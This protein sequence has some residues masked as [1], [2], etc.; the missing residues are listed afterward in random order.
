MKKYPGSG[1]ERRG[2]TLFKVAPALWFTCVWLPLLIACG[3]ESAPSLAEPEDSLTHVVVPSRG[4]PATLDVATWNLE[5]FGDADRGPANDAVQ[6]QRAREIVAGSD[7]DLW[8]LQEISDAADFGE[9]LQSLPGYSG[10]LA[11]DSF[12]DGGADWYSDFSDTEQKVGIVYRSD[13]VE[14][15]SARI[16]LTELDYE[17]AGRPPLEVRIRVTIAGTTEDLVV[18]VLH[19]KANTQPE[20][21]QRRR[22]AAVGLRR[23][24]DDV[25]P[26]HPVLVVG[27]WNDDLDQSI[28]NGRDTPYRTFIDASAWTFLTL[29]VSEAGGS[30][31]LGFT[32]MVDHILASDE[33]LV[34]YEEGSASI[35]QVDLTVPD[36][37]ETTSDHLPVLARFRL[38]R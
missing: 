21:W 25:W 33:A 24:L 34:W 17:F 31:I 3:G 28:V 5:F 20:S 36:Y 10:F 23:H 4:T 18:V 9:L 15:L 29:P 14:V 16:V 32:S 27:D 13:V 12:V 22:D 7:L 30:S 6:R 35:H 1:A 37:A 11:N 8:G 19:A 38:G 2:W 26:N